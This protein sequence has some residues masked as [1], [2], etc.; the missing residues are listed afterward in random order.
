MNACKKMCLGIAFAL[1]AVTVAPTLAQEPQMSPEQAAMMAAWEQ[2][3]TPGP[4]H[5]G[6]AE[7][8]GPWKFTNKMW[9]D[10]AA[11]PTIVEGTAVRTMILGG[12]VL[13]ERV[14]SEFMGKPFE[15]LGH[16]GYDNVTGEYWSTWVDNMSTGLMT[17][18]GSWDESTGAGTFEG[19][20]ADPMTGTLKKVRMVSRI[21]EDG[22][23]TNEFF[24]DRGGQWVKTMELVYHRQ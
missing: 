10:P 12:R 18:K 16:T 24:E 20:A 4:Q 2:A 17:M 19:E 3:M 9:E 5:A 14:S 13:E 1:L 15:G 7:M 21:N 6:L 23:E 8:A 22:S 11:D